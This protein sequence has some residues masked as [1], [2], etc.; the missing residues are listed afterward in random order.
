M[1]FLSNDHDHKIALPA[2]RCSQTCDMCSI[3]HEHRLALSFIGGNNAL[4]LT[5]L[6]YRLMI[7]TIQIVSPSIGISFCRRFS[8]FAQQKALSISTAEGLARITRR[9]TFQVPAGFSAACPG[10]LLGPETNNSGICADL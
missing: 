4:P 2:R 3:I 6:L 10:T 7:L 1:V 8:I 5:S 9:L